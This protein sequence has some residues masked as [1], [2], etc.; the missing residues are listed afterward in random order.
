MLGRGDL[1]ITRFSII[2][3]PKFDEYF[4]IGIFFTRTAALMSKNSLQISDSVLGT[5][6]DAG[7]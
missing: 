2:K 1:S 4:H 5:S 3:E 6:A 7:L